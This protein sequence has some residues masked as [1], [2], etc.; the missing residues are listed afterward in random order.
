MGADFVR[1][2]RS[3]S[4]S[5]WSSSLL[6][7][8]VALAAGCSTGAPSRPVVEFPNPAALAA[9]AAR[10]AARPP[11][12]EADVPADGWT[13][14]VGDPNAAV[15]AWQPRDAWD[16]A[17]GAAKGD[18]RARLTRPMSCV[19]REIGRYLLAHQAAPPHEL[20]QFINAACGVAVIQTSFQTL[21]G[22]V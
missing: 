8:I 17:F 15:E 11:V 20:G 6:C 22:S 13:I 16:R 21:R 4:L 2:L 5:R 9:I 12:E 1:V 14:E 10:P 19:A 7:G 18:R 3:A